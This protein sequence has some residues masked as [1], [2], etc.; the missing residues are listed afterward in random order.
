MV[1]STITT[2]LQREPCHMKF[3]TYKTYSTGS[4]SFPYFISLTDVNDDNRPDIIVAN[5][6]ASNVGV[7][8]NFQGS[9]FHPQV[10]YPIGS[11]LAPQ[12]I[13]V[14]DVNDD[15][16]PD[17]IVAIN[18]GHSVGVLLNDGSGQFHAVEMYKTGQRT[19]PPGVVV[20]DVN[21]DKKPDII[22]TNQNTDTIGVFLNIGHGE[23]SFEKDYE[24]PFS[25]SPKCPQVV[26]VNGDT[27]PD[28]IVANTRGDSIG[29]FYNSGNGTFIS[30][31]TFSTGKDSEP[32]SVSVVDVN[33][34]NKPDLIV[35]NLK[36]SNVGVL[37][38]AGNGKF[39]NQTI[40]STGLNSRPE[41]VFVADINCDSKPDII[42]ANFNEQNI[43][44]F[45]NFGNGTFQPQITYPTGDHTQP[46]SMD[47]NS[48]VVDNSYIV[49]SGRRKVFIIAGG[50]LG[51]IFMIG[52]GIF[53]YNL[54][55][56]K[57]QH[58]P[59]FPVVIYEKSKQEENV[60]EAN[61]FQSGTWS[62]EYY[63]NEEWYGPF[64]IT[65]SFNS[66]SMQVTGSGSDNVGILTMNGVYSAVLEQINITKKYQLGTGD[67]IENKDHEV[68]IQLRWH[69]TNQQF[70]GSS[71]INYS[72]YQLQ[73]KCRLKF[74]NAHEQYISF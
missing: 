32:N 30:W 37:L 61:R 23:F 39:L 60:Q 34:D 63:H 68:K 13:S 64:Q 57:R 17:I 73:G 53:V 58:I 12:S 70:E 62:I 4:N 8:F 69:S 50:S 45:L 26:D 52:M 74:H 19:F 29:I 18:M 31:T 22:V 2:P 24:V 44:I 71:L 36:T 46:C 41:S 49:G 38:N 14:V 65:L 3:K 48:T 10:T 42:V 72:G 15:D 21:S 16:K 6:D 11:V 56:K 1:K 5:Q 43:G 25:F 27:H 9:S 28:I 33:G 54:Y 55:F 7:F 66:Q 35:G 59:T 51:L 40:Y 20:V 47:S 67:P